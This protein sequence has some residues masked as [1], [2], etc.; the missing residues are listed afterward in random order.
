ME[1]K[2]STGRRLATASR[3]S[4]CANI[5]LLDIYS[6]FTPAINDAHCN[7]S[8]VAEVLGVTGGLLGAAMVTVGLR[9]YVRFSILKFIGTD[10]Y[11]MLVAL[12][13]AMATFFCFVGETRHGI[14]RHTA[15]ISG[16]DVGKLLHWQFFHSLWV[17]FGVVLVK[18]SI[19][20]FLIRLAPK[21]SWKRPIWGA[22]SESNMTTRHKDCD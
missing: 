14:G 15:C 17:M 13:M 9:I 11:I 6:K 19:A 16:S 20:L 21:A 3:Q 8:N 18:I 10:D 4:A 2:A 7:E 5:M 1:G 22:I 12:L